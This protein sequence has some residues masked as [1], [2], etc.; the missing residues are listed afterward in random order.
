MPS[1]KVFA[2][3]CFIDEDLPDLPKRCN[4]VFWESYQSQF[5][6]PW[7]SLS[8]K[9]VGPSL[10]T[11]SARGCSVSTAKSC[12]WCNMDFFPTIIWD[13]KAVNL[14]ILRS[15]SLIQ[16]SSTRNRPFFSCR[17]PAH[18]LHGLHGLCGFPGHRGF[19]RR[20][21]RRWSSALRRSP[22]EPGTAGGQ[23]TAAARRRSVGRFAKRN[24]VRNGQEKAVVL[25][26]ES[27][28]WCSLLCIFPCC[29]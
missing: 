9:I 19:C 17:F 5:K 21:A 28:I 15:L 27:L 12:G 8:S 10:S 13:G 29:C 24:L 16:K 6:N 2:C 1:A 23:A 7:A 18:G 25:V 11:Y 20:S 4:F 26:G 3:R 14:S 22:P